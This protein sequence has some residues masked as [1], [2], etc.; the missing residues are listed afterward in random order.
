[1]AWGDSP[2]GALPPAGTVYAYATPE[3]ALDATVFGSRAAFAHPVAELQP[4]MYAVPFAT[5]TVLVI[6]NELLQ[7]TSA[8]PPD[9]ASLTTSDPWAPAYVVDIDGSSFST[10]P[11]TPGGSYTLVLVILGSE[12]LIPFT[13]PIGV[14][15]PD[16]FIV[17]QKEPRVWGVLEALTWAIS[18]ELQFIGG[19]PASRTTHDLAIGDT[20][21]R[22][23]STLGYPESGFIFLEGLMLEFTSKTD[24]AFEL[25]PTFRAQAIPQGSLVVS[26]T[27]SIPPRN[28]Q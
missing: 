14:E 17:A 13:V 15:D 8:V 26:K 23:N 25:V 10:T 1:M 19:R 3:G 7:V 28:L 9:S 5:P 18:K 4:V 12:V 16:G 24:T 21:L 27:N 20:I 11:L 22:V 2:Y 6:N